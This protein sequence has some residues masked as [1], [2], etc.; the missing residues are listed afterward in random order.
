M[1]PPEV[2]AIARE[3]VPGLGEPRV[4]ALASGLLNDTYRVDRDGRSFSL[5]IATATSQGSTLERDWELKV[6]LQAA[7]RGLA[8]PLVCG[9]AERGFLVHEWVVG[10]PWPASSAREPAHIARLAEL[11]KQVHQLPQPAPPR[12]MR[13][14]AWVEHYG[15]A[16]QG[17]NVGIAT[18]LA[19]AAAA[20]IAILEALPW[21]PA[22]VCHS[23]LHL[24]NLIEGPPRADGSSPLMLLDWEY[25]H[26]S[27]AF[28]DLAGWSANNDFPDPQRRSL[29]SAYLGREPRESEW[30]RCE[31]L[32]WLY[33]YVCL[34]WGQ[35]YLNSHRGPAADGF[36]A[37]AETLN[38]RLHA[39]FVS[40][41]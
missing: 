5:R 33:D 14:S 1:C 7:Q 10:Q 3:A 35:L 31:L 6:L 40:D 30:R 21:P 18:T 37:R 17:A 22:V 27:E 25:A 11:L 38:E 26:V 19:S 9:D 16:L 4:S 20:R 36:A 34:L 15:A 12:I 23:D 24:M 13:P 29:L 28:W 8:P 2:Q 39:R 32:V 41:V